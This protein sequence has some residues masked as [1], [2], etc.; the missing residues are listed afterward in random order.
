M[1]KIKFSILG[2]TVVAVVAGLLVSSCSKNVDVEAEAL[3]KEN[4][5]L[6][7]ANAQTKAEYEDM[8]SIINE[9]QKEFDELKVTEKHVIMNVNKGDDMGPTVREQ[10]VNDIELIRDVIKKNKEKINKLQVQLNKSK[11]GSAQLRE[12][13]VS[14]N[15]LIESKAHSIALLQ[16]ELAKR[17]IK[18]AELDEALATL[19]QMN[20]EQSEMISLQECELNK[21]YYA[22][23]TSKELRAQKIIEKRGKNLLKGDFNQDYFTTADLRNVTSINTGS[24]GA[25]ILTSHPAGTYTMDKDE[26]KFVTINILD[27]QLFWST[28]RY[29]VV[30]VE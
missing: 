20:T 12:S 13:I 22:L 30:E 5:S 2:V 28:T 9:I 24:K 17:D 10:I 27:P 1:R 15:A 11:N 25:K 23:G 26:N 18:I 16:E 6:M 19:S 7:L 8:L 4:D 21:V 3:K 14:L 29:L